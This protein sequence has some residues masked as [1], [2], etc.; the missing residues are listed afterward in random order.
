MKRILKS[1][2]ASR[3]HIL[4]DLL[5]TNG[6][7]ATINGENTARMITPFIMTEPS[8]WIYLDEQI[9]DALR[10]LENPDYEVMNKV[11]MDDFYE[12]A[13]TIIDKPAG[14]GAA[15]VHIGLTMTVSLLV[16]FVCI[17]VLQWFVT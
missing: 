17:K 1:A 3:L 14:L 13:R 12:V 8:L 7:P 6:I 11:D 9:D 4:K 15:F 10:L 2:D 5:E 16:L